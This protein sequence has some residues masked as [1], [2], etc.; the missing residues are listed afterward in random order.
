VAA[1]RRTLVGWWRWDLILLQARGA[2]VV[3]EGRREWVRA[4]PNWV[5]RYLYAAVAPAVPPS[6]PRHAGP[7]VA[8]VP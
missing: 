4:F 3:L 8:A 1:D 2:G 6:A 5:E 7:S